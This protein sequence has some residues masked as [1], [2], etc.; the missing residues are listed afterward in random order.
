MSKIDD[1][2]KLQQLKSKGIITQ[3]EFETEKKKILN[4]T[5]NI[6]TDEIINGNNFCKDCG[7][8]LDKGAIFCG[9]CGCKVKKTFIEKLYMKKK[10]IIGILFIIII[11]GIYLYNSSSRS[12]D[13]PNDHFTSNQNNIEEK[14]VVSNNT[15]IACA[16]TE[17]S[18]LLRSSSTASWGTAEVIDKDSYGRYLVYVPLEAQNGFGGYEKLY[19]LVVVRDVTSDGYYKAMSYYQSVLDIPNYMGQTIPSTITEY[20]NGERSKLISDFLE[21]NKWEEPIDTS[22]NTTNTTNN[23]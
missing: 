2:E 17:V 19:Y 10:W 16:K 9:K 4:I 22:T 12:N 18:K 6:V 23:V 5:N 11:I 13:V 20:K 1:L 15:I 21:K 8:K 3:D 14:D 7:E